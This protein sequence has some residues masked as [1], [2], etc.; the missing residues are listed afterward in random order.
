MAS[1]QAIAAI[2]Q[3]ILGLLADARPKPEF[4]GAQF[5]LVQV[6][7]FQRG[8]PLEEGISLFLYRV[9]V[10]AMPRTLQRPPGPD[11][12]R[13]LPS[14][15][16]DLCYLISPWAKTAA[17]Q[18]RLLGWCMRTLQ[19]T[20]RLGSEV[21]NNYAPEGHVFHPDETVDLIYDPISIPDMASLWDILKPNVQLSIGYL[22]RM[23]H[24]ESAIELVE[25]PRVQTRDFGY[26]RRNRDDEL[27][28]RN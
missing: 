18:Q 19:D 7:D 9:T 15:P 20:P 8:R 12:K 16:L 28:R 11:G 25:A 4:A 24:I 1:F 10:S 14:L 22:A 6:S 26:G 27:N 2:S 21:L 3:A 23:I 5:E 17:K 13:Y